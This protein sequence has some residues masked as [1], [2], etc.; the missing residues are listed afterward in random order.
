MIHIL[1]NMD[2]GVATGVIFLDLKKAFETVNHELLIKKLAK[3]GINGNELDWFKSYLND[4][5]QAVH[6]K[7]DYLSGNVSKRIG[8]VKHVKYF[9]PKKTL[10]MLSNALVIPYF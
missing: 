1:N 10:V 7:I 4:R 2:K 5:S 3:Y 8:V 6:V 9:L